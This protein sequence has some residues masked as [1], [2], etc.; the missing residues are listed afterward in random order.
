MISIGPT[1]KYPHSP[2]EKVDILSVDR[3]YRFLK[4]LLSQIGYN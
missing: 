2:N 3:F 1:I 4:V